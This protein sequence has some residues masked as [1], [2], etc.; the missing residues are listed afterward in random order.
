M[1]LLRHIKAHTIPIFLK[2]QNST[3]MYQMILN[4]ARSEKAD[5]QKYKPTFGVVA[6]PSIETKCV[7]VPP[8]CI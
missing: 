5:S 6:R 2:E 4:I 7:S 1:H 8:F 3:G